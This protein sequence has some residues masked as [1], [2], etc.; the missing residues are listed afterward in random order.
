MI[1]LRNSSFRPQTSF[2]KDRDA[3]KTAKREKQVNFRSFD[4]LTASDQTI[5]LKKPV[6]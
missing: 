4:R 6:H 2:S 1:P 5:L 3:Y